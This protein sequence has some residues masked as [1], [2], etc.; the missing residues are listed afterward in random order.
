MRKCRS[1]GPKSPR[2]ESDA[3][4]EQD[5]HQDRVEK[6]RGHEKDVKVHQDADEDDY[7]AG[8]CEQPAEDGLSVE[9]QYSDPENKRDQR[10]PERAESE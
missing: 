3:A 2:D 4:R 8:E 1:V 5:K 6:A 10:Q 9:K 7:H